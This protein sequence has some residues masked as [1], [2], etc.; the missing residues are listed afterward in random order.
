MASFMG[1]SDDSSGD[2]NVPQVALGQRGGKMTLREIAAI[3][4][5]AAMVWVGIKLL[6]ERREI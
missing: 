2:S 5:I 3:G 4:I 1:I 6:I